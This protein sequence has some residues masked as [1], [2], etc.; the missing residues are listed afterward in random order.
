MHYIHLGLPDKHFISKDGFSRCKRNSSEIPTSE[1]IIQ[2][3]STCFVRPFFLPFPFY[4]LVRIIY[5]PFQACTSD[6][7]I[8]TLTKRKNKFFKSNDCITA[9]T[10][11]H[12]VSN[13]YKSKMMMASFF[14]CLF[15]QQTHI[16]NTEYKCNE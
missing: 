13:K 2:N 5:T 15:L 1:K 10:N 12:H 14:P 8:A 7:L 11:K 3:T 6:E 4:S 9:N 16:V